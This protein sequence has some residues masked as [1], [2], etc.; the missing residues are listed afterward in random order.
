MLD[1]A[2]SNMDFITE[3]TIYDT[4][5]NKMKDTTMMII[6]HRLGTIR[7][8][9]RIYVMDDGAVVESGTHDE[10]MATDGVY[11]EMWNSQIGEPGPCGKDNKKGKAGDKGENARSIPKDEDEEEDV[12]R[13]G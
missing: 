5:F 2:T 9:D 1:E 7:K 4:L 3:R 6:A 12:I 13:Y 10:L 8:C 11:S